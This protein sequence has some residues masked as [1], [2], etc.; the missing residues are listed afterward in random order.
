MSGDEDPTQQGCLR[1]QSKK[2][3]QNLT[4]PAMPW[5]SFDDVA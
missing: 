2:K 5:A 3:A 1:I 4:R